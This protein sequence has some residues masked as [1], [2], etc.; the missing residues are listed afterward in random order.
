MVN[1]FRQIFK[2]FIQFAYIKYVGSKK[3]CGRQMLYDMDNL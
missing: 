3:R 1:G 2:I